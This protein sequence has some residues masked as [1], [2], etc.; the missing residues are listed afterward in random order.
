MRAKDGEP[1][2]QT[3]FESSPDAIFLEDMAG[4]VLDCT[5]A[6]AALHGTTREDLIGANVSALVPPERRGDLVTLDTKARDEFE[7]FSLTADGRSIPVSIRTS[8]IQYLGQPALLLHVRDITE[9]KRFE[10]KL[11]RSNDELE[12]RVQSRTAALARANEILRDEIAERNRSEAARQRLEEEIQAA[13]KMEAVGRL[14]GG[15]AHDFNNLL[16]VI[17]GRSEVLLGRLSKNHPMRPEL[18]V[19]YDAAQKA[20]GVTRQLLAFGR[21]QVLQPKILNLNAVIDNMDVML[22]S[23]ISDN[24]DLKCDL[25]EGLWSVE[26]DRGQ[27]EQVLMNLVV[28]ALD[29]MP[30]GGALRIQTCNMNLEASTAGTGFNLESGRYVMLSIQDS[31]RGMDADTL[32]HIFEPFFTTKDK[33]KGT[34]L[35]LST[36]YGIVTQSG[37]YISA[38]SQPDQG[39]SFKIYLPGFL[40]PADPLDGH[41]RMAPRGTETMLVAEDADWVRQLTREMLEVRG[42]NVI[43]APN[44]E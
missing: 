20:S 41:E 27:I 7:G 30:N 43:E 34:G 19:I 13:H 31:G 44:G 1:L 21:K 17:I 24:I 14:A 22:R 37:G 38:G 8:R 28:N 2:F 33:S 3:F 25:G 39:T 4:N 42:Y 6:A 15:V 36:V 9:R 5:P 18:L 32:T 12:L 26:A 11:R 29:A 35:G 40:A 23:L 10:E 16:T